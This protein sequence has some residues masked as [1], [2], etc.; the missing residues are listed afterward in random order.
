[1][2][3]FPHFKTSPLDLVPK[4]VPG[5]YRLIHDLSLPRT[6]GSLVN[7]GIPSEFYMFNMQGSR[8]PLPK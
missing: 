3:P 1:M 4:S 2:K 8:M 7:D 6:D 5:D